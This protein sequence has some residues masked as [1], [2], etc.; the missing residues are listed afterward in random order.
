MLQKN[1]G[2]YLVYNCFSALTFLSYFLK[3]FTITVWQ[4]NNKVMTS[5]TLLKLKK[6]ITLSWKENDETPAI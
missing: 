3:Y 1:N 6:K 5:V 2:V 4:T